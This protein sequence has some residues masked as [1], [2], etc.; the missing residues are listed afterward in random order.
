LAGDAG[1]EHTDLTVE[2]TYVQ[3]LLGYGSIRVESGGKHDDG[4]KREF[5]RHIPDPELVE[6][7]VYAGLLAWAA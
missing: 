1:G 4:A 6:E 2:Q 3:R 5:I 7:A